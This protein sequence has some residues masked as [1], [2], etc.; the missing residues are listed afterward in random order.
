MRNYIST[1]YFTFFKNVSNRH[2]L[3][4]GPKLSRYLAWTDV[5]EVN[6]STLCRLGSANAAIFVVMCAV[7]MV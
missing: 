2:C 5:G 1:K 3:N 4:S 7:T 6:H